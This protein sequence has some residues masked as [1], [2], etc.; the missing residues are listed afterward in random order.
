MNDVPEILWQMPFSTMKHWKLKKKQNV[1]M[2]GYLEVGGG[3]CKKEKKK[4][5]RKCMFS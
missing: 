4:K 2:H 1:K 5:K 3:V